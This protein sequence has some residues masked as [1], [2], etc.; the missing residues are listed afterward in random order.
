MRG[1]LDSWKAIGAYLKRDVRTV[2]RWEKEGLPVHRHLHAKKASIYAFTSEIDLWWNRDRTRLERAGVGTRASRRRLAWF[3]AACSIL[4]AAGAGWVGLSG[5]P[6]NGEINSI[7]VLPL[8]N[9]TGDPQQDYFVDGMTEALI[10]ELG[11]INTLRVMSRSSVMPY[12]GRKKALQ[13]IARELNV[14]ALVEGA[15]VREGDRVRVTAQLLRMQPERQL[16]ADRYEREISSILALQGDLALAIANEVRGKLTPPEQALSSSA[17]TVDPEAYEAYL[18]GRFHWN[19]ASAEGLVKARQHFEEAIKK[20]PGFAPAYAA[21]ADTWTQRWGALSTPPRDVYPKAKAAALKA[22][23]LDPILAEAHAALA[24][25]LEIYEWD[26]A[27]AER[28]YRRAI[29]L[30]PNSATV[31]HWYAMYLA[32]PR[33]F[34]EAFAQIKR[35]EELDPLSRAIKRGKG[36]LLYW[37]GEQDRAIAHYQMLLELDRDFPQ[38][39]YLLGLAYT[40]KGRYEDAIAAHLKAIAQSGP[41]SRTTALLAHAYGKSG[42]E[43]EALRIIAELTECAKT[44]YVPAYD[45]AIAHM[46]LGNKNEALRWLER[47]Y[48]ERGQLGNLARQPHWWQPLRSDARFQDL[49][50]RVRLP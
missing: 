25:V 3:L 4:L 49:L 21:L 41:G 2:R 35:A 40:V 45:M 38:G 26:W 6:A 12:K 43:D 22:L 27:G 34:D 15:V 20:D 44:E 50:R 29:E 19:K 32:V 17:R 37:A 24:Y 10:T 47:A 14:D 36:V 28:A 16:W 42:K 8:E 33:R 9:L 39:H 5:R 11:R 1:R 18:K 48:E 46:G 30:N 23:E 7:A 31:R 13:Q